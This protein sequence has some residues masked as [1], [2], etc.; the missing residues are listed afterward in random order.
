MQQQLTPDEIEMFTTLAYANTSIKKTKEKQIEILRLKIK[1][2]EIKDKI[3][4]QMT[5]Q[6]Q[7]DL[8]LKLEDKLLY[9]NKYNEVTLELE[10]FDTLKALYKEYFNR[11]TALNTTC[12][13]C[14]REMINVCISRYSAL[15]KQFDKVAEPEP[16]AV[17]EKKDVDQPEVRGVYQSSIEKLKAEMKVAA[18]L[19]GLPKKKGTKKNG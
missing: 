2:K 6:E 13:S 10:D 1:I 7:Y 19:K 11:F 18:E 15:K 16:E 14:V 12:N 9:F 5:E 3:L 4:N 17:E 8:L